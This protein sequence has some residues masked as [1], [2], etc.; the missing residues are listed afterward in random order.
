MVNSFLFFFVFEIVIFLFF[1]ICFN[2]YFVINSN[3]IDKDFVF[4]V[5]ILFWFLSLLVIIGVVMIVG[6]KVS[7]R[8]RNY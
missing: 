3:I 4:V 6:L 1:V 5:S 2:F 7:E 8:V